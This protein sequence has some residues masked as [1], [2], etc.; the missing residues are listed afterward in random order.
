TSRHLMFR[1]F[2]AAL[3]EKLN[4][5]VTSRRR[6]ETTVILLER[7]TSGAEEKKDNFVITRSTVVSTE[8]AKETTVETAT[9]ID[10]ST[11]EV[12]E[13]RENCK[14]E[15][16]TPGRSRENSLNS[17]RAFHEEDQKFGERIADDALVTFCHRLRSAYE[18]EKNR[19]VFEG[20]LDINTVLI[21]A[22]MVAARRELEKAKQKNDKKSIK[23]LQSELGG[24]EET[25]KEVVKAITGRNRVI[26]ILYDPDRLHY[27]VV[28]LSLKR[29]T[30]YIYD[31]L[32]N[33]ENPKKSLKHI[34]DQI[35]SLFG[36]VFPNDDIPICFP[37]NYEQQKDDWSCGYRAI[38]CVRELVMGHSPCLK[39]Y[40]PEAIH[41][42][43]IDCLDQ[44]EIPFEKFKNAK[45]W[46]TMEVNEEERE[47]PTYY[48][49]RH[50]GTEKEEEEKKEKLD[51]NGNE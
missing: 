10:S 44:A 29:R 28:Y 19:R 46:K 38:A 20:W 17:T 14:S 2:F 31:S 51:E 27:V 8:T 15:P 18:K 30:L 39:S 33:M 34:S 50:K 36:H 40:S 35:L 11:T 12:E 32:L 1:S 6:P 24:S 26:Q 16:S 7:E 47:W 49:H 43:L 21:F 45:L 9:S 5:N 48:V 25:Q 22:R 3:A 41:T 4:C 13:T 37:L 23:S 42:L